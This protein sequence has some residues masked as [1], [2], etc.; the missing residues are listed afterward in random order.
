M[1]DSSLIRRVLSDGR[2]RAGALVLGLAALVAILAPVITTGDPA[3]QHDVVATRFLAPLA[4]DPFGGFHL[5]GTDRFGRDLWTRLVYG[6]RVSLV[7]GSL[8][9]LISATLGLVIGAVAGLW[10]RRLGT[11]L[12]AFTD[13][14]L[15]LPRVVLLL[16]L[17]AL[18]QPSAVLVVLVLGFTGWMSVARLV[19]GE[20]R[21]LAARPENT[22]HDTSPRP[23]A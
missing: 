1:P 4:S 15:S 21:S 23:R 14:A 22:W 6:A 17:A 10:P 16:L 18:W 20:V 3:A 12:L 2:G 13:F 5:L 8:A 9:V 7:V 11:A 19:H